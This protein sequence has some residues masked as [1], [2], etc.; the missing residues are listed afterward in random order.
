MT[1]YKYEKMYKGILLKSNFEITDEVCKEYA[2][3]PAKYTVK[4]EV[5][6]IDDSEMVRGNGFWKK[7]DNVSTVGELIGLLSTL[8]NDLKF[9]QGYALL[10]VDH[11]SGLPGKEL[12]IKS[13]LN[14]DE[15]V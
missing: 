9:S 7:I 10:D 5:I 8:P 1:D 14:N 15:T 6:C 3:G 13:E 12:H 4:P 11:N 2:D